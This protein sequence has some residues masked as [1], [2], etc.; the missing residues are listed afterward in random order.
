MCVQVITLFNRHT[1]VLS[2]SNIVI[3]LIPIQMTRVILVRMKDM[4]VV[5]IHPQ[6]STTSTLFQW[7]ID[8]KTLVYK[9]TN[10][11]KY[12]LQTQL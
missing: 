9:R 3:C 2:N 7:Y 10:L 8:T 12:K 4:A 5:T 6:T 1:Q 11:G